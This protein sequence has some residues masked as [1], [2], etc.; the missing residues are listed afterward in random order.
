MPEAG[1]PN[2]LESKSMRGLRQTLQE[3][4]G[5]SSLRECNCF[6]RR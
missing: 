5:D 4:S 6:T 1:P 2:S 3:G